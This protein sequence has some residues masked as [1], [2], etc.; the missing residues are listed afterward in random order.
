MN[1]L[2]CK[3]GCW[4]IILLVCSCS[5]KNAGSSDGEGSGQHPKVRLS[6]VSERDVP[7][8]EEYTATV[9]SDVRNHITSNAALRIEHILVDV[10]DEVR[11]GQLLVRMDAASLRQLS[12]QVENLRVEFNRMD[13]L[14]KV[15]GVSKSEWDNAKLQLDVNETAYANMSENTRLVSPVN[16]VVTARYYDDGDMAGAEPILTVETLSP[17]KMKINVSETYYP[18]V[19]NGMKA[20]VRAEA[21]GDEAFTGIVT[22]VY[23]TIDAATHTFPVEITLQNASHR[24]RPGM[25]ARATLSFGTKRHTVVPDQAVVKQTGSGDYYVYEYDQATRAVR[26]RKVQ[27]GRRL[28]TEYEILDGIGAG[29]QVVV[30]GQNRLS[31]GMTVEVIR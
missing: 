17:V 15:G 8:T 26:Y 22:T 25:F 23:P 2:F 1:K 28:G 31:D 24:L 9:E 19:K 13:E 14:Y 10:G 18:L 4:V 12:L 3:L 27:I 20:D 16:G 5:G 11:K 29:G 7:Q 6:G 30:A 21:Y